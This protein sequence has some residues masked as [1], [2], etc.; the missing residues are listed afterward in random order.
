ML[1]AEM[2]ANLQDTADRILEKVIDL[3]PEVVAAL[4]LA[5][6]HVKSNLLRETLLRIAEGDRALSTQLW[7]RA[8]EEMEEVRHGAASLVVAS[9]ARKTPS[10]ITAA[11]SSAAV[12]DSA[13]RMAVETKPEV[14]AYFRSILMDVLTDADKVLTQLLLPDGLPQRIA[15][16][17]SAIRA[18]TDV[19]SRH[20]LMPDRLFP[21]GDPPYVTS[22]DTTS[23]ERYLVVLGSTSNFEKSLDNGQLVPPDR[24]TWATHRY[25]REIKS[26]PVVVQVQTVS[27]LHCLTKLELAGSD[28]WAITRWR[29]DVYEEYGGRSST[30]R[31]D[32]Q[33]LIKGLPSLDVRVESLEKLLSAL[34]NSLERRNAFVALLLTYQSCRDAAVSFRDSVRKR[35]DSL[36]S[37]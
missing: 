37:M 15:D 2:A 24:G 31:K 27:E 21:Y 34:G 6:A 30:V 33:D 12:A 26:I 25:Y 23:T 20:P 13:Y 32:S 4:Y 14:A 11:A 22:G 19:I 35:L 7:K 18:T 5:D 28:T 3:P 1:L 17:K 9:S 8:Q 16:C 29:F 10:L 36:S